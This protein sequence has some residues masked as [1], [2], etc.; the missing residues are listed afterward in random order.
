MRERQKNGVLNREIRGR[1]PANLPR[2]AYPPVHVAA[3]REC[4]MGTPGEFPVADPDRTIPRRLGTVGLRP[5]CS[6][7]RRPGHRSGRLP[8]WV[9]TN[10]CGELPPTPP[11]P[12]V[13][14]DSGIFSWY[15]EAAGAS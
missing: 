4:W 15:T 3:T 2:E 11:R 7:A 6:P 10:L 13:G 1:G 14:S 8:T 5:P 12:D 9:P